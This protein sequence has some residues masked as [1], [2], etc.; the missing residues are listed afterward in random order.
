MF[1]ETA[2]FP[3]Y[4]SFHHKQSLTRV[5]WLQVE[6]DNDEGDSDEK[7]GGSNPSYYQALKASL[8]FLFDNMW[9]II[10]SVLSISYGERLRQPQL[11]SPSSQGFFPL[12]EP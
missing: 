3:R 1:Q 10:W 6:G 4:S 5:G 12:P 7:Y 2:S 9:S 8:L 11:Q